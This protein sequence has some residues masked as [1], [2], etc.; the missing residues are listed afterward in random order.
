MNALAA[1]DW[2]KL[3]HIV[4]TN[5][6]FT[7]RVQQLLVRNQ[8]TQNPGMSVFSSI[9]IFQSNSA[10]T[11]SDRADKFLCLVLLPCEADP[12]DAAL[13]ILRGECAGLYIALQDMLDQRVNTQWKYW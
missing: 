3:A 2:K 13:A 1:Y 8:K 11:S 5:P 9:R 12:V 4:L 10:L 7:P 6:E